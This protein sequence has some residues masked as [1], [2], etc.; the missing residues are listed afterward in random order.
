MKKR[1]TG[2]LGLLGLMVLGFAA[3]SQSHAEDGVII[4]RADHRGSKSGRFAAA[5][6]SAKSNYSY[7]QR[8]Y[9]GTL[10]YNGEGNNQNP[11]IYS[12][13]VFSLFVTFDKPTVIRAGHG[14][15][16]ANASRR[17]TKFFPR[18]RR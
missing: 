9:Q 11:D 15:G 5:E 2:T 13:R 14:Y 3:P 12:S 1:L 17:D 4:Y 18:L 16:D 6:K 10:I 7:T 8:A